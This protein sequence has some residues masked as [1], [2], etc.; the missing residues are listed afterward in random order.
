MN[1]RSYFVFCLVMSV[2]SLA[3]ASDGAILVNQAS[4]LAGDV[5]PGDGPGFP[6]EITEPG[7]YRLVGNL[8]TRGQ[9]EPWNLNAIVVTAGGVTLDLNG[10]E[11]IGPTTCNH[12]T[13]NCAPLAS[14]I[15]LGNG[16]LVMPEMA[17]DLIEFSG[18]RIHNGT[19]RGMPTA[20]LLSGVSSE[21]R[22]LSVIENGLQG[23]LATEGSVVE[24]VIAEYNGG[25]GIGVNGTVR[26]CTASYN[27]AQGIFAA[28]PTIVESSMASYNLEEGIFANPGS[29][30]FNNLSTR[31]E[32]NGFRCFGCTMVDNHASRNIGLGVNLGGSFGDFGS[33]AASL[34]GNNFTANGAGSIS[35]SGIHVIAL[36]PNA[37]TVGSTTAICDF[38]P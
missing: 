2:S 35:V 19:I 36:G 4:A 28:G 5:T 31:N 30:L 38:T 22:G 3:V 20:G 14:E 21:V 12:D 37:C 13:V 27:H 1:R 18:F 25:I 29:S 34:S 8:D 15:G 24:N 9:P 7:L 26:N 6:V 11:I 10:F 23:L 32:G 16:V 17:T 33:I